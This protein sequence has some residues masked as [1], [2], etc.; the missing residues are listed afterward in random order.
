MDLDR[1]IAWWNEQEPE[2]AF[3]VNAQTDWRAAFW[4]VLEAVRRRDWSWRLTYDD[5]YVAQ[6]ST[7]SDGDYTRPHKG[8]SPG[9]VGCPELNCFEALLDAYYRACTQDATLNPSGGA[10]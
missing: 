5:Q 2:Y 4:L 6:V 10:Q 9:Y 3:P 1:L 8:Y 7:Y